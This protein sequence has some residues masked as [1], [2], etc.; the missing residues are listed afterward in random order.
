VVPLCHFGT[1]RYVPLRK[2]KNNRA[3]KCRVNF[4]FSE[5]H[6][7]QKL[8]LAK[9]SNVTLELKNLEL[10]GN[11]GVRLVASSATSRRYGPRETIRR[12]SK[13]RSFRAAG[14]GY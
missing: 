8:L 4:T 9:R 1:K 10:R 3:D 7:C 2:Q 13:T 6:A 5:A 12:P 11:D 14:L